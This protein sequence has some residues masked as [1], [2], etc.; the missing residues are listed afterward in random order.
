MQ[1][2]YA[3]SGAAFECQ[4][5]TLSGK[6]EK[7][8]MHKKKKKQ[9]R[10]GIRKEE[11][12]PGILASIG[13]I[14]QIVAAWH[15][16]SLPA[17]KLKESTQKRWIA[18]TPNFVMGDVPRSASAV[19]YTPKALAEVCG[20]L[21][22]NGREASTWIRVGMRLLEAIELGLVDARILQR[23]GEPGFRVGPLLKKLK[24]LR[25]FEE[26]EKTQKLF[27]DIQQQ[28]A[29]IEGVFTSARDE[30]IIWLVENTDRSLADI[31]AEFGLSRQRVAQ[32]SGP[33]RSRFSK[34]HPPTRM[35]P[36]L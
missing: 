16:R 5:V 22:N 3:D 27:T 34:I 20:A 30:K 2:F 10:L 19:P 18:H 35:N 32:I 28:P 1:L 12:G 11:I 36:A 17:P 6:E 25:E 13:A 21:T 7:M 15:A 23:L 29:S 24:E 9:K 8:S 26:L 4:Q 31:G 14:Q 33:V